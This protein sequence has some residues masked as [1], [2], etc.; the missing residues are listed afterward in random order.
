MPVKWNSDRDRA[1]SAATEHPSGGGRWSTGRRS[2]ATVVSLLLLGAAP[3]AC[4]PCSGIS[5]CSAPQ[6]VSY[7][8]EVVDEEGEPV[9]GV[10]VRFERVEGVE[11]AADTFGAVTDAHGRFHVRQ[12]ASGQGSIVAAVTVRPPGGNEHRTEGLQLETVRSGD[13][14]R[15]SVRLR[16]RSYVEYLLE[17]RL[18]ATGQPLAGA[19]VELQ[20]SGGVGM[21]G[22]VRGVTDAVGR[23]WVEASLNASGELMGDLRVVPADLDSTLVASGLRF[24]TFLVEGESRFMPVRV[25]PSLA[26]AGRLLLPVEGRV[27][28]VGVAV[29][30]QRTG[31]LE[32]VDDSLDLVTDE[33]GLFPV[34][35][36]PR[37]PY[38]AGEVVGRLH[39]VP[40]AP[41]QPIFVEEVRLATFDADSVR[42]L[43]EWRL[44]AAAP[45]KVQPR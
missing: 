10:E 43:D 29:S 44:E 21:H 27:A 5:T 15:L 8:G 6:V 22:P 7:L 31:G 9:P 41:Y 23:V 1:L 2:A 25:G 19:E 35:V 4:D 26:Y 24:P 33:A 34:F 3:V 42:L 20:P 32:L 17:L 16:H 45:T 13:T 14:R 30:F 37:N 40:P 28:A 36:Q 11:L 12:T 39:I 38:Q 18:R